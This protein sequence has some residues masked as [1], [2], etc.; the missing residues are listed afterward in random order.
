VSADELLEMREAFI[1]GRFDV[2]VEEGSFSFR[3]YH[4]MLKNEKDSI[5]TFKTQQQRAFDEERERWIRAGQLQYSSESEEASDAPGSSASRTALPEGTTAVESH[6]SGSVWKIQVTAGD[7][8]E[9]GAPLVIVESM[10]MEVVVE[11]PCA[12]TVVDVPCRE[13][14]T[15]SAGQTLVVLRTD[16]AAA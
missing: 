1:S 7:H 5:S 9:A 10:K 16:G 14:R 13:G 4:A 15:V 3:D 6:V 12:G 2:A 8:V 11:A